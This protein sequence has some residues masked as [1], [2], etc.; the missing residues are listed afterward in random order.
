MGGEFKVIHFTL[1]NLLCDLL[2]GKYMLK[3]KIY[4]KNTGRPDPT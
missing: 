2:N 1:N 4:A 3:K